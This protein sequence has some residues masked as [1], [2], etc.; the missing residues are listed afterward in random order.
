MEIRSPRL[1]H[2]ASLNLDLRRQKSGLACTIGDLYVNGIWLCYTL[3][4][5]VR[6]KKI[7]GETAIPAGTY[8][9]TFEDS[10]KFGPDTLTIHDVPGFTA[11][12]IHSGNTEADTR[13]CPLV[14]FKRGNEAIYDSRAA[15][16]AL[17]DKLKPG[18]SEGITI[19]ITNDL[20]EP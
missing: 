8:K 10:P 6:A 16:A 19:S 7:D 5:I 3:E 2:E 11:I 1:H 14:G 15:L 4:D 9:V 12:R 18:V 17:K 13:G 20:E